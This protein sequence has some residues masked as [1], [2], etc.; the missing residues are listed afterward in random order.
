MVKECENCGRIIRGAGRKYCSY[1]RNSWEVKS[2]DEEDY[3][4]ENENYY[5]QKRGFNWRPFFVLLFI[6]L[7]VA[8]FFILSGDGKEDLGVIE[9]STN[10]NCQYKAQQDTGNTAQYLQ[11]NHGNNYTKIIEIGGFVGSQTKPNQAIQICKTSF[12]IQN[13]IDKKI[14]LD[15]SYTITHKKYYVTDILSKSE[16]IEIFPFGNYLVEN[17]I[18]YW[19]PDQSCY[20]DQ[21]SIRYS[22][23][24]NEEVS[25]K[26][27]R[28]F[29]EVCKKCGTINC[30][31]DNENCSS[32]SQCG[33]GI[34]NIA[35]FCSSE[36]IIE[37]PNGLKNC[38]NESC[39]TPSSKKTGEHY[40]C[41]WECKYSS[42][43]NGICKSSQIETS[44]KILFVII[45][46]LIAFIVIYWILKGTFPWKK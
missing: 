14:N 23:I 1:C 15:L 44:A 35:G 3:L 7:I 28:I 24:S 9:N 17:I 20:V 13:K 42:G 16:K 2:R 6:G 12:V 38:N 22:F 19:A 8:S 10:T 39:L 33:S 18:E 11:D 40:Q 41:V 21:N 36:K 34:C 45:F 32:D 43:E 29:Q 31:N 26:T 37:C 5:T 46:I 25:A 30:L 27:E 4:P